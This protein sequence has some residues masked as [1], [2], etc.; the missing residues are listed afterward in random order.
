MTATAWMWRS[1]WLA[2]SSNTVT[3]ACNSMC[4]RV[5]FIRAA[6]RR[7]YGGAELLVA[8]AA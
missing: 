8:A 5:A 3:V 7:S 2:A 4:W 6:S 1:F